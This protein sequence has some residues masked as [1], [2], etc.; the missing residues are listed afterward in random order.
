MAH[1]DEAHRET[2]ASAPRRPPSK[3]GPVAF[4]AGTVAMMLLVP[5]LAID[6][7]L[8]GL[9]LAPLMPA[10]VKL[11]IWITLVSAQAASWV[12]TVWLGS[13]IRK[14]SRQADIW[15]IVIRCGAPVALLSGTW[16]MPLAGRQSGFRRPRSHRC[17]SKR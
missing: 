15:D 10:G 5:A 14:L 8:K 16:V 17:R 1:D 11:Q 3:Y 7:N 9:I 4:I 13:V 6:F 2:G 12:I